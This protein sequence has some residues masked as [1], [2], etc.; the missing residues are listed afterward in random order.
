MELDLKT[1]HERAR[2]EREACARGGDVQA[3]GQPGQPVVPGGHPAPGPV[4]LAGPARA[5]P[6]PAPACGGPPAPPPSSPPSAFFPVPLSSLSHLSP[7]CVAHGG[8]PQEL[9][10]DLH[11]SDS[12]ASATWVTGALHLRLIQEA[13]QQ[14][15][16]SC[17]SSALTNKSKVD[18]SIWIQ[19]TEGGKAGVILLGQ[20]IWIGFSLMFLPSITVMAIIQQMDGSHLHTL[21]Q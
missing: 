7:L 9:D 2:E 12:G 19:T 5:R 13:K 21:R 16:L 6:H 11:S 3:G 4:H 17:E 20:T 8:R 15:Y 18:T 10:G 1:S 14:L